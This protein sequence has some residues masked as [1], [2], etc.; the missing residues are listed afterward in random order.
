MKQLV[1]GPHIYIICSSG[2]FL[3]T[4]FSLVPW[5][6][7]PYKWSNIVQENSHWSKPSNSNEKLEHIWCTPGMEFAIISFFIFFIFLI[8]LLNMHQ[9][10]VNLNNSGWLE[11]IVHFK[12]HLMLQRTVL[13]LGEPILIPSM[14]PKCVWIDLSIVIN[15]GRKLP[16]AQASWIL[17]L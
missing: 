2:P 6:N 12:L 15:A 17:K 9:N 5:Y 10:S 11:M 13:T 4:A 14:F 8:K 3:Q 7:T 1:L 16:K